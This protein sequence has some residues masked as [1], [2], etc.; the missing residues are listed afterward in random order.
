MK[1]YVAIQTAGL[2]ILS[3]CLFTDPGRAKEHFESIAEEDHLQQWT[4][5]DLLHEPSGD[6]VLGAGDDC[7]AIVVYEREIK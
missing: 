2:E 6:A 5:D 3:V 4:V 1:A 7:S